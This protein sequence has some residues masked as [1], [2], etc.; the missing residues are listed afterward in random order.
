MP[1]MRRGYA[2]NGQ[3]KC[4]VSGRCGSAFLSFLSLDFEFCSAGGK[5]TLAIRRAQK[6]IWFCTESRLS[7]TIFLQSQVSN[8]RD[9]ASWKIVREDF[10]GFE[11]KVPGRTLRLAI[12]FSGVDDSRNF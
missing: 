1:A 10:S 12:S 6:F 4:G 8:F 11:K 7:R 5:P 9:C 2:W 3:L